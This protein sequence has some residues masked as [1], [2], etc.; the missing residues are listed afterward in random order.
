[1]AD[2][3]IPDNRIRFPAGRLDFDTEVGITGQDHDDYPAPGQ[4]PRF[5]WLRLYLIALLS[6]Q[7]SYQEPTQY[8]DGTTWFDLNSNIVKIRR[9]DAWVSLAEAI[10]L[11]VD[12]DGEPVTLQQLYTTIK[13]LM[14]Y[15]PTASF[16]GH[17]T[18][19]GIA[20]I[21]IPDS[22][23]SA[24]GAGSRPFVWINGDLVDPRRSDYVGG[25]AP[26]SIRLTGGT[27]IDTDDTFIVL[28]VAVDS[29]FFSADEVVL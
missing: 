19:D 24:A 2:P 14:G 8:R 16:S 27:V 18:Q 3:V 21:P 22:L 12:V 20:S 9:N 11:D 17:S 23:R 7:S 6:Q 4:Q 5:D 25:T 26:I 15:K 29:E 10:K 1:M 28:M 13:T